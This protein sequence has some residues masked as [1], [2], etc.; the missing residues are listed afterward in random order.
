MK[1]LTNNI[2]LTAVVQRLLDESYGNPALTQDICHRYKSI[3]DARENELKLG[4]I[5][6]APISTKKVQKQYSLLA[7]DKGFVSFRNYVDEECMKAVSAIYGNFNEFTT[8][9]LSQTQVRTIALAYD[10]ISVIPN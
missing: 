5:K 2:I 6:Q 4:V 7:N 10:F 3:L 8:P 9:I 1:Y